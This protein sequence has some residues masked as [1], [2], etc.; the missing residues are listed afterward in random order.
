MKSWSSDRC[1][2]RI[3]Y[4]V[5]Q[6]IPVSILLWIAT[7]TTL[8]TGTYCKQSNS[9]HFAH[10]W[11][12]VL[13]ACTTTIAILNSINFYNRHKELLQKHRILLKLFT[14]KSVLGLNFF[15]SVRPDFMQLHY[16]TSLIRIFFS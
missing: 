7:A 11:L 13:D 1:E 16:P 12:M 5:L 2:Q 10:I 4:S 14:F 15:Q 6:F 9:T 3:W 8:I